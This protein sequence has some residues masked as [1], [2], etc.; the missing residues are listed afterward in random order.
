[1][2]YLTAFRDPQ[3]V[4]ALAAMIRREV[5]ASRSYRLLEFCGGHTHTIARYGLADLLPE[6]IRFVHGPGCPVCILP[7]ARISAALEIAADPAVILCA[8]GD[9]VR[10]PGIDGRS[11]LQ[12][13]AAG[14]DVRIV[15]SAAEA[16]QLAQQ[17]QQQQHRH[18]RQVVFFAVGFETTAPATAWVIEQAATQRLT[19]FSVFC[20]HVLTPPA[21][22]ALLGEG[23]AVDGL[24]GPGHVSAIV[25]SE[26]YQPAV[27]R[28][29]KPLVVAGFEPL[30]LL[31]AVWMLV[32]QLNAG[33]CEVENQYRRGVDRIGN[34]KAQEQMAAVFE[35]RIDFTW[36][37]LGRLPASGLGIR[38]RY[39]AFDA[40]RRFA[41]HRAAH[42][43]HDDEPRHCA[44]GAILRGH[45]EP[46][47]CP[48]FATRC[49][50][51]TPQGACMV[52]AE[53]ACAADYHYRYHRQ[54]AIR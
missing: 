45:K 36:R 38:E 17:Q 3:R 14:A 19:H 8:Y 54:R 44:C 39:A 11:L 25:G 4:R 43:R 22:H 47:E 24:I 34:R 18:Q 40:E 50:P 15:Y 21:L 9:T 28:F 30:D 52:S 37:G 6:A 1:M 49:T 29:A 32:Q 31:Q 53:G 5:D 2:R 48:L 26:A 20:N 12:A 23:A 41:V 10:V 51:D 13:K 46:A 16:L 7:S 33:R 42:Q 27:E 35:P